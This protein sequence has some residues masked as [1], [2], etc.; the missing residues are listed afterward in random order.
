MAE[1]IKLY[2][3]RSN[4]DLLKTLLDNLIPLS[5]SSNMSQFHFCVYSFAI[6]EYSGLSIQVTHLWMGVLLLSWNLDTRSFPKLLLFKSLHF[7]F[8][9]KPVTFVWCFW[10]FSWTCFLNSTLYTLKFPG[11]IMSCKHASFFINTVS[12]KA[13][14]WEPVRPTGRAC[15]R[16]RIVPVYEF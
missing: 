1:K 7:H 13:A 3:Y 12:D 5:L 6:W 2:Y 11:S 9:F 10:S 4:S 14:S 15:F 16:T 8:S